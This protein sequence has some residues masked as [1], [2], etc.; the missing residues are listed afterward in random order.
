M[1]KKGFCPERAWRV[2]WRGTGAQNRRDKKTLT[3][4]VAAC[5]SASWQVSSD[6]ASGGT[7]HS[8]ELDFG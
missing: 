8:L 7:A 4:I 6:E 1:L 3:N 2:A 5:G